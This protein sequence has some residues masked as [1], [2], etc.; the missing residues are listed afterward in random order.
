[1]NCEANYC[2][3]NKNWVCILDKIR[4]NSLSMCDSC[5]IV[6]VPGENL[7]QYKNERLKEIDEMWKKYDEQKQMLSDYSDKAID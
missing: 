3:Y 5:E 2:I 7:E 4:I 1:M 6:T